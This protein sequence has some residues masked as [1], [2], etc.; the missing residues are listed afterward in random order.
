MEL[1]DKD[2]QPVSTQAQAVKAFEALKTKRDEDDLPV[3]TRTKRFRDYVKTYLSFIKSGRDGQGMKKASTI[4]KEEYTLDAWVEYLGSARLDKIRLSHI[5]AF[6]AKRLTEDKVSK[7]TV[8]LDI[9]CL[10]NVLNHAL[11]EGLIKSV[12]KLSKGGRK[13]L[14]GDAPEE[15]K[16][17]SPSDLDVFCNAALETKEDGS[18]VTKNGQQFADYLR[19]MALSGTRRNEALG[20]QW[21]DLAWNSGVLNVS[22]QVTSRGV[23]TLKNKEPRKVNFNPKLKAHLLDMQTRKDPVSKWLFP[24]PQRGDKDIPAKTFRESLELV[25]THIKGKHPELVGKAFHDLR[26]HFI[27]YCV[28]SGIDYMTIAEWVGHQD[29]GILIGKVYGHLADTHK[30]EQAARVNFGPVLLEQASA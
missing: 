7:R 27:S 14:R 28:M 9:I 3:L 13:R 1:L 6:T 22:R 24:S 11:D 19:I 12:P 15:R 30:K 10:T 29:G 25:R 23:E 21:T 4:E 26:H 8:A 5:N 2:Q 18:P 16:L 17:L 20:L